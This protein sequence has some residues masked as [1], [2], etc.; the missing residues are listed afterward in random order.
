MRQPAHLL[1]PPHRSQR[2][3][4]QDDMSLCIPQIEYLQA[5]NSTLEQ[6]V[7]ATQ[8][9]TQ[10]AADLSVKNQELCQELS[11]IDHLAKQME[12]D[13]ELVLQ[14]ADHGAARGQG[15]GRGGGPQDEWGGGGYGLKRAG[16]IC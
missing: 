10:E 7:E 1:L 6:K 3:S 14:T 9:R 11:H 2:P 15:K 8:R 12:M 16:I 13:K 4:P 5:A